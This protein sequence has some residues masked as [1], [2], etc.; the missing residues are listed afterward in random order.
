VGNNSS[1]VYYSTLLDD[2]YKLSQSSALDDYFRRE[3]YPGLED[4]LYELFFPSS[5]NDDCNFSL[6][7]TALIIRLDESL[8]SHL[9]GNFDAFSVLLD[10]TYYL[11]HEFD[12]TRAYEMAEL[13]TGF[14]ITLD[15]ALTEHPDPE[16]VTTFCNKIV[17]YDSYMIDPIDQL[18]L[19]SLYNS[20]CFRLLDVDNNITLPSCVHIKLLITS[21][22]VLHS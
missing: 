2:V 9:M 19:W 12:E 1:D 8:G 13:M 3:C 14:K 10:F 20:K 21:A 15:Y 7:Q 6:A 16:F 4:D 22:D 17:N 18:R 5:G 11:L